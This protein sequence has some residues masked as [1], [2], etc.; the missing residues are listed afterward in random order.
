MLQE[1]IYIY[2][3]MCVYTYIYI[4]YIHTYIHIYI[5]ICIYIYMHIYLALAL[6]LSLSL[7]LSLSLS[8]CPFCFV[9]LIQPRISLGIWGF[10]SWFGTGAS[11]MFSWGT[12]FDS[13][14]S[15]FGLRSPRLRWETDSAKCGSGVQSG[16]PRCGVWAG[17]GVLKKKRFCL[18]GSNRKTPQIGSSNG[19]NSEVWSSF[20]EATACTK[21]LMF[22][23][24]IDGGA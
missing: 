8:F 24:K 3:H 18:F 21:T 22:I 20:S 5:Y 7:A 15:A 14:A 23:V 6:S 11:A 1:Y 2:I 12:G 17:I 13:S 4:Q 19:H 9:K 16:H 10:Q